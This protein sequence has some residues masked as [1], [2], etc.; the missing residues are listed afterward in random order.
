[1][2]AYYS[3]AGQMAGVLDLN[4]MLG[5]NVPVTK[6]RFPKPPPPR[7]LINP[8]VDPKGAAAQASA[9]A[10]YE[11]AV[12]EAKAK[13][14]AALP[15]EPDIHKDQ[16]LSVAMAF[17]KDTWKTA[18]A[19]YIRNFDKCHARVPRQMPR[20]WLFWYLYNKLKM[21][22]QQ[23]DFDTIRPMCTAD[24]SMI[25]PIV[26]KT[27]PLHS[28]DDADA[29]GKALVE[30][31]SCR[32]VV[33]ALHALN[34]PEGECHL[35]EPPPQVMQLMNFLADETADVNTCYESVRIFVAHLLQFVLH[36]KSGPDAVKTHP[37][38]HAAVKYAIKPLDKDF[39]TNRA[40]EIRSYLYKLVNQDNTTASFALFIL[41]FKSQVS[42]GCSK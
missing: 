6:V 27:F 22:L 2:M 7:A 38:L 31:S 5:T 23:P 40:E 18:P 33:M 30:Q 28:K 12:A 9:K 36:F 39:K 37:L 17:L 8:A 4:D 26:K 10:K 3:G 13:A 15:I 29:V 14:T 1:M 16:E 21:A 32:A 24:C 11:A 25:G 19:T 35:P 34:I 42:D 41:S 20:D